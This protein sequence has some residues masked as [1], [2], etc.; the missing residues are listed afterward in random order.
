MVGFSV[1]F[2][3]SSRSMRTAGG[4]G[5]EIG[6]PGAK[7][8]ISG[9]SIF[10]FGALFVRL[11]QRQVRH[12]GTTDKVGYIFVL[13]QDTLRVGVAFRQVDATIERSF[14]DR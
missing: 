7:P 11:S 5:A 1:R 2:D 12:F 3:T 9:I 4:F 10:L 6:I 8:L 14:S 13:F